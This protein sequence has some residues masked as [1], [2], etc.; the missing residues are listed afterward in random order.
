MSEQLLSDS[1]GKIIVL[2]A[3]EIRRAWV[4]EQWYF[5]VVD[6]IGGRQFQRFRP[7]MG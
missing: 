1:Q 5:S 4:N 6:I 2:G 3:K 7:T